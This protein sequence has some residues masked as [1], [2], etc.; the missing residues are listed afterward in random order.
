MSGAEDVAAT[1]LL[2]GGLWMIM[3]VVWVLWYWR[4]G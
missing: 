4:R 1:V 3:V 2:I